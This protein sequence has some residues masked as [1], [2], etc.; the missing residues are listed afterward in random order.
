MDAMNPRLQQAIAAAR[1]GKTAQAKV[2]LDRVVLEEPDNVHAWFLLGVISETKEEQAECLNQ[3]L[4]ID[5]DHEGAQKR[6]ALL[7]EP[8][9]VELLVESPPPPSLDETDEEAA[10]PEEIP[11]WLEEDL[12]GEQPET[13]VKEPEEAPV[14]VAQAEG[15]DQPATVA[16]PKSSSNRGLEI[17]LGGL[18]VVAVLIVLA[19][20]YLA[21]NYPF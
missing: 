7:T 1:A 2:L 20:V 18:V 6:L 19:L 12:S 21:L 10:A 17:L 15:S 8:E 3:V 9:E 13:E 5:P 4:A 16:K 14:P 11:E